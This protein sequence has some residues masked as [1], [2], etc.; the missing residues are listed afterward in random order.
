M[1]RGY[2]HTSYLYCNLYKFKNLPLNQQTE[3]FYLPAVIGRWSA[4]REWALANAFMDSFCK[5][6]KTK[7]DGY[8]QVQSA[9]AV[10]S[11]F[12]YLFRF[13]IPVPAYL[14]QYS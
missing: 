6:F 5:F 11:S 12:Y 3:P 8:L 1:V 7:A 2:R 14:Q 10:G 9:L 13:K 4:G